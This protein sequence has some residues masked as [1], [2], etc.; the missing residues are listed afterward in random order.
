MTRKNSCHHLHLAWLQVA[1]SWKQNPPSSGNQKDLTL[2]PV[3]LEDLLEFV[4]AFLGPHGLF[5]L[6]LL[7]YLG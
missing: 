6:L 3:K 5:L 2:G 1:G 4:Q 7:A